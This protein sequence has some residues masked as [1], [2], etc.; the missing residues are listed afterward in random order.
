MSG[1]DLP[2]PGTFKPVPLVPNPDGGDLGAAVRM[3][4]IGLL[5]VLAAPAVGMLAYQLGKWLP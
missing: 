3:I 5:L 1:Y 2:K 4:C